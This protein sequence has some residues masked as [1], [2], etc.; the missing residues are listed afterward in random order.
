ME[1]NSD[2][3]LRRRKNNTTPQI[4]ETD[5]EESK[6]YENCVT[7]E[8]TDLDDQYLTAI[9]KAKTSIR[10]LHA[11]GKPTLISNRHLLLIKTLIANK[12]ID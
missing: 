12:T 7:N 2:I 11:Y 3:K 5:F 1:S 9:Q 6:D 8:G 4:L 10:N